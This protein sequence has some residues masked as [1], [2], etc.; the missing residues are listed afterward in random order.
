MSAAQEA[1]TFISNWVDD[2]YRE[3]GVTD[4]EAID[5]RRFAK[6]GEEFG[7]ATAAFY[8]WIGEN[9]RK[10]VTHGL[11][12]VIEEL[13]DVATAALGAV[14]HFTSEGHTLELLED[15]IVRVAERARLA[16]LSRVSS[17]N[18]PDAVDL[19][20]LRNDYDAGSVRD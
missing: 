17:N 3:N 20:R 7:E 15:K 10:G 6:A 19:D 12:D 9:P 13:L 11:N 18:E 8:G 5:W 14:E 1:L 16:K 2:S 4:E